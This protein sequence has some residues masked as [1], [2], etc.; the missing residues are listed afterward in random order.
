MYFVKFVN[1][2]LNLFDITADHLCMQ[3]VRFL[4]HSGIT[5]HITPARNDVLVEQTD[6]FVVEVDAHF[7]VFHLEHQ[8]V[9]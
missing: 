9:D 4:L 8:C 6:I 3:L 1:E 5:L 2:E 7:G